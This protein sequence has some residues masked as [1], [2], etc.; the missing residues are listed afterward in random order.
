M[1]DPIHAL[2]ARIRE[3]PDDAE[4][5]KVY[6]DW[7]LDQGDRRGE[8]ILLERHPDASRDPQL[9]S[10]IAALVAEHRASWTP[11]G[12]YAQSCEWRGGFVVGATFRVSD[13]YDPDTLAR[14]LADPRARFLIDLRLDIDA[15]LATKVVAS[16]AK[17]DF[18]RLRSLRA[19]HHGRGDALARVLAKQRGLNLATLDLRNSVLTNNGLVEL[20]D[21]G[22]L[23]GLRALHLQ[24]NKFAG[25]GLAALARAELGALELLD[26]R[27]NQITEVGAAA[28]ASSPQLGALRSLYLYAADLGPAGVHALASSTTLPHDIVRYWRAQDAL[29]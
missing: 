22:Q 19:I 16:M 23:R 8:L 27:Y 24:N 26:L 11:A 1:L 6:A 28:L 13:R 14:A 17:V 10:S 7:L 2:E 29:Q 21:S 18:G 9:R 12:L 20:A 15:S 4:A 5:W 25:K 3:D